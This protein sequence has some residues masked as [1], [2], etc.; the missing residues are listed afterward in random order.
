MREVGIELNYAE[1]LRFFTLLLLILT[2]DIAA[3]PK[4]AAAIFQ[5]KE[6][7]E[8]DMSGLSPYLISRLFATIHSLHFGKAL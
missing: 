8:L 4:L 6:D 1:L 3:Y 5:F 2:Q 7:L